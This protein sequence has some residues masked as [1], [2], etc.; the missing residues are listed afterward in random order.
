MGKVHR[1][2]WVKIL[3][4]INQEVFD[5]FKIDGETVKDKN[6][7]KFELPDVSIQI[8][9]IDIGHFIYYS[10]RVKNRKNLKKY[11][12]K[13]PDVVPQFELELRKFKKLTDELQKEPF[14]Q[15]MTGYADQ[16]LTFLRNQCFYKSY[17]H[18]EETDDDVEC[19]E[20]VCECSNGLKVDSSKCVKHGS[21]Q[22]QTC[23]HG[24]YGVNQIKYVPIT[25][26]FGNFKNKPQMTT[27]CAENKCNC[28]NGTGNKGLECPRNGYQ[29][30]KKCDKDYRLSG[31][32]CVLARSKKCITEKCESWGMLRKMFITCDG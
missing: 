21:Q 1:K 32:S 18:V 13:N 7:N 8:F 2:N 11:F 19:V 31:D 30:C 20:N 29:S 25:D 17:F 16:Q 15:K 14:N 23:N 22:C 26:R 28:A 5:A 6:G 24:Y 27:T 9:Y 4:Q 10:Q 3:N 12:K